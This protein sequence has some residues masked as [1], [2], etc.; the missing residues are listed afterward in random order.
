MQMFA[1][2]KA[3]VVAIVGMV[4]QAFIRYGDLRSYLMTH[5]EILLIAL[6]ILGLIM[7]AFSLWLLL[8]QQPLFLDRT[9]HFWGSI[10][11]NKK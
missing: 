3:A 8:S 11:R 10:D 2:F 4:L 7:V 5:R 9:R 6:L 1:L